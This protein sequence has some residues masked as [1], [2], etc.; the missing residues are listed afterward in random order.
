MYKLILV[1]LKIISEKITTKWKKIDGHGFITEIMYITISLE[2]I[3]RMQYS[4]NLNLFM[5]YNPFIPGKIK[6]RWNSIF[7]I[8]N[9]I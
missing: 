4:Y 9:L 8:K 2:I 6:H 7:N 1:I 3:L 5:K